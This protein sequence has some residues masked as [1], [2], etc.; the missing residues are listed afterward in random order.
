MIITKKKGFLRHRFY[1]GS[2][3]NR[4][5]KWFGGNFVI[6]VVKIVIHDA[7]SKA[8]KFAPIFIK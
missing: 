6:I 5:K 8:V 7:H 2:N 3:W 1:D 4:L